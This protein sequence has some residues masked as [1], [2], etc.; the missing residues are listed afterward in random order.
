PYTPNDFRNAARVDFDP[1]EYNYMNAA[2]AMN[3]GSSAPDFS[4][5]PIWAIFDA[6]TVARNGW[7]VTPPAVD[8]DGYWFS[9]PTVGELAAAIK[10]PYQAV[11]ITPATLEATVARY[12]SFV[13]SGVD[14]DFGKVN[15]PYKIQT[16]PFYAAWATPQVHDA[17]AGL[18]I[19]AK[20]Q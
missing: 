12:N 7:S 20:C 13:D 10:N 3:A 4:A 9:A 18:R 11:A 8:P 2:M 16:P 5:G 15:P 1:T 14:P 6:D 19:N 17:R